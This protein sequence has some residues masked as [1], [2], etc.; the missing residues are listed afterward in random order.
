MTEEEYLKTCGWEQSEDGESGEVYWTHPRRPSVRSGWPRRFTLA[1]AVD[2]QTTEDRA[3]IAFAQS[4][5]GPSGFTQTGCWVST[6]GGAGGA[7]GGNGSAAVMVGGPLVSGCGGGAAYRPAPPKPRE[8]YASV[9]LIFDT[10]PDD[11]GVPYESLPVDPEFPNARLVPPSGL[12][13]TAPRRTIKC[14]PEGWRS[15]RLDADG[16]TW[17]H[18]KGPVVLLIVAK[19]EPAPT[20]DARPM[21]FLGTGK[22]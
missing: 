7:S 3:R 11:S 17:W 8:D 21:V 18:A 20:V 2:V 6:T 16:F 9:S 10:I 19:C 12:I 4:R 14:N 5:G 13:R 22:R 1:E 15:L